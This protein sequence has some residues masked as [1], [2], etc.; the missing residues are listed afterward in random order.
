[1]FFNL[2]AAIAL[3]LRILGGSTTR[4]TLVCIANLVVA[5]IIDLLCLAIFG[6]SHTNNKDGNGYVLSTAYW[7]TLTSGIFSLV[8][9]I[10]LAIDLIKAQHARKHPGT[11][12][13][14]QRSLAL[15]MFTF[16]AYI[17]IGGIIYKYMLSI[18]FLDSIYF[19]LQTT[20]TVGGGDILFVV[21]V[22]NGSCFY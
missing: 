2:T 12:T 4:N 22:Y 9:A 21:S 10:G 18:T 13:P 7:L 20:L 15:A 16:M 11:L 1:M 5:V 19:V 8:S 3:L 17:A 14:K 6:A